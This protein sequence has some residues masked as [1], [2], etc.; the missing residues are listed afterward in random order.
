V[1]NQRHGAIRLPAEAAG[2]PAR[3][4]AVRVEGASLEGRIAAVGVRRGRRRGREKLAPARPGNDSV[5]SSASLGA[6]GRG[7]ARIGARHC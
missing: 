1:H 3:S 4:T 2:L 5:G 7:G 6:A